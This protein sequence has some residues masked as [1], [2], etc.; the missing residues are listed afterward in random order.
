MIPCC[1]LPGLGRAV[2]HDQWH[3]AGRAYGR[4]ASPGNVA[5]GGAGKESLERHSE[6][7]SQPLHTLQQ[8]QLLC[9]TPG[10]RIAHVSRTPASR[11]TLTGKVKPLYVAQQRYL[12]WSLRTD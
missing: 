1:E 6:L 7:P 8:P 9:H 5:V 4:F 2:C 12:V 10:T 11:R 3:W